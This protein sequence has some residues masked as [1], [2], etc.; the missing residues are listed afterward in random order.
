M[1]ALENYRRLRDQYLFI[2]VEKIKK[3]YMDLL[4]PNRVP[5][6]ET[7]ESL[8]SYNPG[9]LGNNLY[10]F[11]RNNDLVLQ[12]KYE[13]HDIFHIL[14]GYGIGM[15]NEAK[16]FFFLFGNGKKSPSII[17]SMIIAILFI[18]ELWSQFYKDYQR[19]KMYKPIKDL[20]F[21]NLLDADFDS[22]ISELE[23]KN[24]G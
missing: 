4:H 1:N 11:L 16:L 3:I 24:K 15:H 13:T 22:L 19:G 18:P 2:S 6:N 14:S 12:P 21:E 7:T 5:W 17:G 8:A 20:D 10:L 23:K 9:T